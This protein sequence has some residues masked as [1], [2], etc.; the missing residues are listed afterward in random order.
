MATRFRPALEVLCSFM[1]LQV[2]RSRLPVPSPFVAVLLAVRRTLSAAL[3]HEA[4]HRKNSPIHSMDTT[5][6]Y[7]GPE[8]NVSP[9]LLNLQQRMPTSCQQNQES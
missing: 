6:L 3:R 5:H 4:Y 8:E 1:Q 9:N 2:L 7:A